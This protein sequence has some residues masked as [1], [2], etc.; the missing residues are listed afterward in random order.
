ML[1]FHCR[2][3]PPELRRHPRGPLDPAAAIPALRT[4]VC[5][6]C[7]APTGIHTGPQPD[8]ALRLERAGL[9]ILHP[10]LGP[11]SPSTA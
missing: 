4:L 10:L 1:C 2:A 3:L 7:G 11:G 6:R 9:R 5:E 8:T